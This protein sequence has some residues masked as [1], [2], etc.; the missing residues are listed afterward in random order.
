M[1]N[2]LLDQSLDPAKYQGKN[3]GPVRKEFYESLCFFISY[4]LKEELLADER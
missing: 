4:P 1:A 3:K 2:E